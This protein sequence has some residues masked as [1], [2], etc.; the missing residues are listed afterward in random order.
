MVLL[1]VLNGRANG[2]VLR[3][4]LDG[5]FVDT[6]TDTN[7]TNSIGLDW[8]AS[9]AISTFLLIMEDTFNNSTARESMVV[10]YFQPQQVYEYLVRCQGN[11]FV[12]DW[13]A[14]S[15]K[16]LMLPATISVLFINGVGSVEG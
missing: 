6:F 8:D 11:L 2:R 16:N 1:Y 12:S 9:T 15:V 14:G 10:H 4:D 13:N 7:V 3:H 5:N